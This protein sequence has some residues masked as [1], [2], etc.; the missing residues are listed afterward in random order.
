MPEA[1]FTGFLNCI[2]NCKH[3]MLRKGPHD[4]NK[5]VLMSGREMSKLNGQQVEVIIRA[6]VVS[7]ESSLKKRRDIKL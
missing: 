1:R 3:I 2:H 5:S 6:V 7:P 4:W